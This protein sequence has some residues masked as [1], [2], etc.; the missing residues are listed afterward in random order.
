MDGAEEL[1]M[2]R[3]DMTRNE[4]LTL[5]TFLT[6]LACSISFGAYFTGVFGNLPPDNNFH[7][8]VSVYVHML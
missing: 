7:I 6:I 3:L 8:L 4:L 2:L 1:V 5:N